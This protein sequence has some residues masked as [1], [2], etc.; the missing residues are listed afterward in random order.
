MRFTKNLCQA[1]DRGQDMRA[2]AAG[3]GVGRERNRTGFTLAEL[4]VGLSI[5]TLLAGLA[6]PSWTNW[7]AERRVQAASSRLLLA[8]AASRRTAIGA[9]ARVRLC[10]VDGA[11]SAAR[12]NTRRDW[13]GGWMS[14]LE[15]AG[16]WSILQ[17]YG[18]VTDGVRVEVGAAQLQDG[19][20]FD[21]RGFATQHA[22]GFA[23][24]TWLICAPGAR[25]QTLTLAPSGRVRL[26]PGA[27]CSA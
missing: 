22:G 25:G 4:L 14:L 15:N 5:A 3:Q 13:A 16:A 1:Q 17:G 9:G 21:T 12:C 2:A 27:P 20:V 11:T 7:L 23:A 26:S 24:G 8:L 10:A 19:V 6:L 18:P